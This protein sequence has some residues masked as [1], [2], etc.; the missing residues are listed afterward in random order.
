[1]LLPKDFFVAISRCLHQGFT[2]ARQSDPMTASRS[3]LPWFLVPA[4]PLL[5]PLVAMRFNSGVNWTGFDFVAAYVLLAGTGLAYRL[6]TLRGGGLS[7]RLATGVAVGACLL[8]IWV[9]LAVGFIGDEDNPANLLYGAV[10]LICGFGAVL[11]RG[12]PR[13]LARTAHTAAAAQFLVP[14]LAYLIW[15]PN[16][17]A[18]VLKI[19][20]LNA[21]WVFLFFV[22]GQLYLAA[23]RG[24]SAAAARADA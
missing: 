8:L 5:V 12:A 16:F 2:L 20:L 11:A 13:G 9:N 21:F 22:S 6:L 15:R 19:F 14:I 24:D 23:A 1:M 4:L 17:D 7:Y 18:N 10:L 3:L